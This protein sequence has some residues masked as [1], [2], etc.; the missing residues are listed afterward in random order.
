MKYDDDGYN[1]ERSSTTSL[2]SKNPKK[3]SSVFSGFNDVGRPSLRE[4]ISMEIGGRI[5]GSIE[6]HDFADLLASVRL[7]CI[8][9]ILA[10]CPRINRATSLDSSF[11]SG[12]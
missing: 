10:S 11:V 4:S 6:L 12:P 3:R 5:S 7:D 8:A 1:C 9:L 2:G